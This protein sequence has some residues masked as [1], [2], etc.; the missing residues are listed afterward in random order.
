MVVS[1]RSAKSAWLALTAHGD[2]DA[3]GGDGGDGGDGGER[4]ALHCSSQCGPSCL[5][6]GHNKNICLPTAVAQSQMTGDRRWSFVRCCRTSWGTRI[7][8]HDFDN[9]IFRMF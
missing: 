9:S 8:T 1:I 3:G 6:S 2:L 4:E 5:Q 7:T